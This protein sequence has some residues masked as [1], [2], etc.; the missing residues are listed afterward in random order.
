MEISYYFWI[1]L[2]LWKLRQF[3]FMFSTH[4]ILF[5][6]LLLLFLLFLTFFFVSTVF[7]SVLSN[8]EVISVNPSANVFVFADST[9]NH[10][11]WLTYS[12]KTDA[13]FK[14]C[15]NFLFSLNFNP[16]FHFPTLILNSDALQ[17]D[18]FYLILASLHSAEALPHLRSS[19][20]VIWD[21]IDFPVST[22]G[23]AFIHCTAFD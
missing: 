5:R 23:K 22:Q 19:H 21:F 16:G 3:L 11:D 10:Q 15:H 8:I 13:T 4:F 17:P 2:S 20:H 18:I 9:V 12:C 1:T 6:V 14:F 7:D